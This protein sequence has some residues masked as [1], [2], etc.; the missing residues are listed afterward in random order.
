M[1]TLCLLSYRG[2]ER[3]PRQIWIAEAIRTPVGSLSL[4][5]SAL[6]RI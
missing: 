2:N 3:N 1:E 6:G 4:R 5:A